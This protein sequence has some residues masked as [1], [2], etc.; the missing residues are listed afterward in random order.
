M[1]IKMQE[2]LGDDVTILFCEVQGHGAEEVEQFVYN[3][4]W[5]ND[6]SLWTTEAPFDNGIQGIPNATLLGNDGKILWNGR[7]HSEHAKIMDLISEQV[8]LAKKGAKG[9]APSCLKA[10]ADFEKGNFGAAIKSLDGAPDAEKDEA[11]KLQHSLETR[12]NAK[13]ARLNWYIEAAQFD[14]AD[15]LL[16][17]LQKGVVGVE[18]LE[19]QVKEAGE[20]LAS[21]EMAQEREAGKALAKTEKMLNAGGF[22]EVV[23]KQLKGVSSKFPNTRA[24]KRADHLLQ[25][26]AVVAK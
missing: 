15:K 23:V 22:D 14:K 17:V 12:T 24:A 1:A 8:K 10:S 11:K 20:R 7:P 21:K 13:L 3:K 25:I 4:K 26:S 5:V 2:E 16:P 18:R 19:G 9:M 6:R